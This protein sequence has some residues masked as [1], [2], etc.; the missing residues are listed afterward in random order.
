MAKN[1]TKRVPCNDE[2]K[3][4]YPRVK[5]RKGLRDEVWERSK[6]QDGKVYDPSGQEIKPG[7]PWEMGHKPGH[8]LPDDRKRA[9]DDGWDSKTWRDYQNDPDIY[10]PELPRTNSGHEHEIVW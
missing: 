7:D 10:R 6:A 4:L 5:H 8:Q 9:Y 2:L 1:L 3:T